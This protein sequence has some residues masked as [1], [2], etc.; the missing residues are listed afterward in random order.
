MLKHRCD[1]QTVCLLLYKT[2][3]QES[4]MSPFKLV[5][6]NST[7]RSVDVGTWLQLQQ[8]V[9]L[10]CWKV[11]RNV[12]QRGD[13]LWVKGHM[14]AGTLIQL[15]LA[16]LLSLSR[17]KQIYCSCIEPLE[18]GNGKTPIQL[19]LFPCITVTHDSWQQGRSNSFLLYPRITL[20]G[21]FGITV[22]FWL[23]VLINRLSNAG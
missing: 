4:P 18:H 17:K 19:V 5:W 3:P 2:K 13:F 21:S 23:G 9:R 14:I 16:L 8:P 10:S 22:L 7:G 15:P 6:D 11:C 12:F 20:L 1:M